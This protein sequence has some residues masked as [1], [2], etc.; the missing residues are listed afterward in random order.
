M[1][2]QR[3][4]PLLLAQLRVRLQLLLQCGSPGRWDMGVGRS[5][6]ARCCMRNGNMARLRMLAWAVGEVPPIK[7]Q[8]LLLKNL[9]PNRASLFLK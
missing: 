4:C 9:S 1:L 7:Q 2:R 8:R 5:A 6:R 3:G